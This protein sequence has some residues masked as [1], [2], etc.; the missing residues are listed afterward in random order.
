[1]TKY[2]V[3]P[4]CGHNILSFN[5]YTLN[6]YQRYSEEMKHKTNIDID[7]IEEYVRDKELDF[8]SGGDIV[9]DTEIECAE[10]DCRYKA[11]PEEVGLR[12]WRNFT[13]VVIDNCNYY[14]LVPLEKIECG[15][16]LQVS[17][18]IL[19]D[20]ESLDNYNRLKK[21]YTTTNV[22]DLPTFLAD[23]KLS[24]IAERRYK[25]LI[26]KSNASQH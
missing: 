18:L 20:Q 19:L 26:G 3:C 21:L 5:N 8:D 7:N 9:Y 11:L 15:K 22:E 17:V 24:P 16:Q 23:G 25:E 2:V 6:P 1:M 12:P 13:K 10:E 14:A 4:R